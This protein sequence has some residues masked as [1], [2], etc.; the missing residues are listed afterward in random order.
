MKKKI[1]KRLEKINGFL[2]SGKSPTLKII[3]QL[4]LEVKHLQA[5]SEL[6]I[7]QN[8]S[9]AGA[10]ISGRLGK[11]FH[12]AGKFRKFGLEIKA[13]E[14]IADHNSF[15]KP[16]LFMEQLE[17]SRRKSGKKLRKIRKRYPSFKRGDFIKY[18]GLGLSSD[19]WQKFLVNAS[20]SI[21]DLFK[22]D[23]ISDIKY[24]HQLRKLLKSIIYIMP[25]CK[26]RVKPIH[27]FLKTRKE[28][29]KSV[30]SKIGSMHDTDFFLRWLEKKYDPI[31]TGE[32]G[33]LRK[34]KR[35]WQHDI[36]T[37]RKDLKPL[38]PVVRRFALEL[39]EKTNGDMNPVTVASSI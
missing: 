4:R 1:D 23:V 13:I 32:S 3:H 31:N 5:F 27:V 28:F 16:V 15:S 36:V 29:M 20:S 9:G 8:N 7:L 6:V 10:D 21:L 33:A 35:E 14:S 2:E 37:M 19:T 39:K 11:L 12:E 17:F 38:L 22:Q 26:N 24:L 30:E 25:V 18:S 34:I